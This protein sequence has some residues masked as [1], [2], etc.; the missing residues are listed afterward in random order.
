MRSEQ[1]KTAVLIP[2]KPFSQAKSRLAEAFNPAEREAMARSM[3]STVITAAQGLR[4]ALVAPQTAQ[5]VRRFALINGARFLPEPDGMDL[6]GAVRY[7]TNQLAA[8]NYERV[9]VVHSDLPLARDL[10]WLA[11][12]DGIVLV[13]DRTG[14]GTNA[15]ALPAS[16]GFR[17]SYGPGSFQRHLEEARRVGFEPAVVVDPDGLSADVDL[18]SDAGIY[19]SAQ[20]QS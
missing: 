2:V 6:N 4:V 11:E 12:A 9:L 5:D 7:A 10:N 19:T 15:I 8:L 1:G 3:L 17:F 14:T 16:C 20:L 13:A 18:P